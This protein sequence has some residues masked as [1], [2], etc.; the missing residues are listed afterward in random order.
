LSESPRTPDLIVIGGGVIGAMAARRLATDGMT[1]A[2]IDRG[3]TDHQSSWAGAG[4]LSALPPWGE[5]APLRRLADASISV[6]PSLCEQLLTDTGVDPEFDRRGVLWLDP[7]VEAT[8]DEMREHGAVW[9]EGDEIDRLV[10]GVGSC[11][12][13][14]H[15][16]RAATVRNPRLMRALHADLDRRGG[17]RVDAE[18]EGFSREGGLWHVAL[19]GQG[20]M[21][22][23]TLLLAAGAWTGELLAALDCRLPVTPVRGQILLM[24]TETPLE[25]PV[26]L[27]DDLYVVPRRDGHLLVGSTV[28][29]VGF[30]SATT[31]DALADL[32]A[33]LQD[34]LPGVRATEVGAWAG[35]RPGSPDGIPYI[36]P[37]PGLE[38]LFVCSGHF[39][40]GLTLA[41]ASADLICGIIGGGE[42]PAEYALPEG[43]SEAGSASADCAT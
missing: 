38:S 34:L 19:A 32:R 29:A 42:T 41:P 3:R 11:S 18:V 27:R 17:S 24:R 21:R 14:L 36:G 10:P 33:V 35:L 8:G 13:A 16:E 1:V 5:P 43:A 31:A 30:D 25:G 4:L 23:P 20:E 37:V 28:E 7:E 40:M 15:L 22:A 9:M 26:L 6:Y 12:R 39:R 2:L